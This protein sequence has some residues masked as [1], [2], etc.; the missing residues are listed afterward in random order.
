[1]H[2]LQAARAEV[3]STTP[4]SPPSKAGGACSSPRSGPRRDRARCSSS[5]RCFQ[6][7]DRAGDSAR[8]S[9]ANELF[10]ALFFDASTRTKSSWAG[11]A[12]RLGAHPVIVDGSS[13]PG[14]PRRDRRGDRRDAGHERPR[15]GHPPR[16]DPGRGQP[17][18]ARRE[19][20]IDDYL[21]PP[22]TSASCRSSTCS[23]TSTTRPRPWP[24]CLAARALPR[25]AGGQDDR[26]EL[27][28]LA[29]AT[30]SRCRCRR[31]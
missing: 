2:E 10:Y 13:D 31:G 29:R 18:H 16:P 1:M 20:G 15:A 24:T 14:L 27:G 22:A 11:A 7:L 17:L 21:R 3:V 4:S 8:R 30:P 12:A 5:P 23:A 6:S 25:G 9:S 28:L 26:G 19:E